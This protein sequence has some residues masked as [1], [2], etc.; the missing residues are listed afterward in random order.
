MTTPTPNQL[1]TLL[2]AIYTYQELCVLC[3]DNDPF[4]PAYDRLESAEKD[5]FIRGLI[6]LVMAI[7]GLRELLRLAQAH[8]PAL[9]DQHQPTW[10]TTAHPAPQ[11]DD[12]PITINRLE[13]IDQ[14]RQLL[15]PYPPYRLLCLAGEAKMG[16]SHLMNKVFPRLARPTPLALVELSPYIDCAGVL[17]TI[18]AQLGPDRFP[19]F[20]QAYLQYVN[21]PPI[22]ADTFAG[23]AAQVS[24]RAAHAGAPPDRFD[25][26]LAIQFAADLRVLAPRP[27]LLLFDTLDQAPPTLRAWLISAILVQLAP[28]SHIRLVIA[29]REVPPPPAPFTDPHQAYRLAPVEDEQEYITYCRRIQAQ[30]SD[31]SVPVL[32]RASQYKPGFFAELVFN[33]IGQ[34]G[35]R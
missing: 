7:D 16:K 15:A 31:H 19:A 5:T 14:F 4:R 29:G 3:I 25:Q 23:V 10:G 35:T 34:G 33:Y 2:D 1:Y 27:H 32:A 26:Y 30:V 21:R 22:Q 9:Y 24:S 11:P 8:N 20:N 17:Q 6:D 13:I 12:Y 18:V 28:L